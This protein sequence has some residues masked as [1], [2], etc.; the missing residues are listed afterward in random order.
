MMLVRHPKKEND[1]EQDI[2]NNI[3]AILY[4]KLRNAFHRNFNHFPHMVF[5]QDKK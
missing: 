4:F 2:E 3:M 5:L 1:Y